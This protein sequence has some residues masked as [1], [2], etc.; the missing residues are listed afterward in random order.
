MAALSSTVMTDASMLTTRPDSTV[1][2]VCSA[3]LTN[4]PGQLHN[5]HCS[6]ADLWSTHV[7]APSDLAWR[8]A[9]RPRT[10]HMASLEFRSPVDLEQALTSFEVTFKGS[11]FFVNATRTRSETTS[12]AFAENP[13]AFAA[14]LAL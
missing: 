7:T 4:W 10:L 3:D 8:R 12:R 5:V 14:C 13:H 9:I 6:Y 11:D 2:A 1:H